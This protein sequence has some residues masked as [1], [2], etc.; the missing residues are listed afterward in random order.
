MDIARKIY[1][2][3]KKEGFKVFLTRSSDTSLRLIDR[4]QLSRQLKA[5]LFIAIHVNAFHG[6]ENVSGLETHF[7]D[8]SP[9]FGEKKRKSFMFVSS[10]IDK[11]L[12]NVADGFLLDKIDCSK[13]LSE[14]IQE[15]VL[16]Y[17]NN[18]NIAIED[19]GVKRTTYRTLLRS[20]VPS[21]IVE[22]G[23]VTN[24]KEAKLFT[25][26]WY[27]QFLAQGI[28]NGIKKFLAS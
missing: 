28:C 16:G 15:G 25:K 8:G 21:S 4:I 26:P 17:L 18:R 7:L 12:T 23:F 20:E 13:T 27:R 24:K 6:L 9:F 1:T 3:L 19:R 14:Y 22:V 10:N 11:E 2:F 5:D